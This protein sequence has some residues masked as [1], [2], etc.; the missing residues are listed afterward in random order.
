MARGKDI[1]EFRGIRHE[2]DDQEFSGTRQGNN[3]QEFSGGLRTKKFGI[4]NEPAQYNRNK[5]KAII[6]LF[7]I[8]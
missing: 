7:N 2:D 4:P 5:K 8:N 3:D 6:L 1:Q